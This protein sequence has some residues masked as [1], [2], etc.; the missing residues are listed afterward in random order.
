MGLGLFFWSKMGT[1]FF[2]AYP[3]SSGFDAQHAKGDATGTAV[4]A[5]NESL[6]G[7]LHSNR[8]WN[9]SYAGPGQGYIVWPAL[10]N[11]P[12]NNARTYH[13]RLRT[14]YTGNPGAAI[15]LFSLGGASQASGGTAYRLDVAHLTN[16]NIIVNIAQENGVAVVNLNTILKTGWSPTAGTAYDIA[17]VWDGTASASSIK[18]YINGSLDNSIS[19]ISGRV[20]PNPVKTGLHGTIGIALGGTT[21]NSQIRVEEFAIGDGADFDL[22]GFTGSGRTTDIIGNAIG[23]LAGSTW[24]GVAK[25]RNDTSWN[26]RGTSRTGTLAL[27]SASNVRNG[28]AYG[29]SGNGSTGTLVV[30]TLA[31]TKTGV[32]GDGGTGTY[33]GSDRWT[34]PGESNV[35]S[36]VAYKANSTSNNKTGALVSTNPGIVNVVE[37]VDY[38]IENESYTGTYEVPLNTD[39]GAENVLEGTEYVI[40]DVPLVGTFD[41]NLNF[42]TMRQFLNDIYREIG[43]TSLTDDEYATTTG[44]ADEYVY[45]S[46]V[47]AALDAILVTRGDIN[48]DRQKLEYYFLAKGTELTVTPDPEVKNDILMGVALDGNPATST[49][50]SN[51]FMGGPVE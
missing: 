26:E 37:G 3:G 10:Y 43:V 45:S 27:P 5:V 9:C 28:T 31:N 36:G 29:D 33:D 25:V 34:D 4:G 6:T 22:S 7:A 38:T 32:A 21:V 41:P 17:L 18:L 42:E 19:P 39:P 2:H 1:W 23:L 49:G 12:T 30:P 48:S 50:K 14:G 35:K 16:G 24:P 47:Y 15:G 46:E 51:I 20:W 13:I 8:V 44:L 11:T 40:N